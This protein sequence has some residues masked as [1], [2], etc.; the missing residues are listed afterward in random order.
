MKVVQFVRRSHLTR[1]DRSAFQ[2]RILWGVILLLPLALSAQ[3][4][5][6]LGATHNL[7]VAAG[8]EGSNNNWLSQAFATGANVGGYTLTGAIAAFDAVV[9]SP[10]NLTVF[11]YDNEVIT[12]LMGG[13]QNLPSSSIGQLSGANP[14][15]SGE[16]TFTHAGLTLSANTTYHLVMGATGSASGNYY[17]WRD[18]LSHDQTSSDGWTIENEARYDF[19]GGTPWGL[20]GGA[21]PFQ[22]SIAATPVPEPHEYAMVFGLGLLVIVVL[23]RRWA[24]AR[25]GVLAEC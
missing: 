11:I 20:G 5:S 8:N 17:R 13:A 6:N 14:T 10:A 9:G 24:T 7:S 12:P 19:D 23:R 4:V 25:S 2:S 21:S 18:T 15:T 1:I 22:F 16:H 3:L